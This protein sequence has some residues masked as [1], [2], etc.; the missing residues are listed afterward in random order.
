MTLWGRQIGLLGLTIFI[1]AC[2]EPG[3]IGLELNPENGVFVAKFDEM[4]I[5]TSV[6]EYE[7]IISDIST[8]IEFDRQTRRFITRG[9]FLVGSYSTPDFG[10]FQSKSFSSLY[11]GSIRFRPK[12]AFVFDSLLLRINVNYLYGEKSKFVGNKKI[13]VHELN[14]EIKLDYLYH[15][16]NSTPYKN[17]PVGEF[18]FDISS[19]DSLSIVDTVF[20]TRL[21]DELGK[22]FLDQ[23]KMD[24]LPFEN[25]LEF[26][27]IF[28]GFAF[29]PE[30][31][32]EIITGIYA[33]SPSTFLRLY[34]HD[35]VDTTFFDFIFDG[36]DTVANNITRYYNN[37]T[38]D[39]AGTPI[40][41]IPDYYTDFETDNDLSYVQASSGIL[42]KLNF[43]TYL[44]FIDTID[45]LVIN[46]AEIVIPLSK[47][48]DF[49]Y[50]TSSL[51]LYIADENNRF[52]E[53][54]D[55]ATSTSTFAS[56]DRI[57]FI[58]DQSENK[59]EFIGDITNYIQSITSGSSSEAQLLIGQQSLSKSIISVNQMIIPKDD[60]QL[61]IYYS[62]LIK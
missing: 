2:E 46:K 33:E 41:G 61:K 52:I 27:K 55:S 54:I 35:L 53:Q 26:R 50:P 56:L 24:T 11:L 5:S 12:E 3:E 37:I 1:L 31:T 62:T 9:R 13:F 6:I 18:N 57:P 15:T 17:E 44:N 32:N 51:E 48:E 38:L 42:T 16:K 25:N 39:K 8:R 4:P 36:R 21:S 34:I 7:D 59:G 14:E 43:E 47:Y 49:L 30:E 29:V 40:Q 19:F 60:I 58:K 23:A 10:K 28:N 22:W 20:S 45:H